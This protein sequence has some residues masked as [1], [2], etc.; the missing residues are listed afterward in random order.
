MTTKKVF[1]VPVMIEIEIQK[2]S[3]SDIT[4]M[5]L[6]ALY[7]TFKQSMTS[8]SFLPQSHALKVALKIGLHGKK[9]QRRSF[10]KS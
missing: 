8:L 10:L 3:G 6:G 1:I 4:L 2:H 9:T 5:Q 7:D